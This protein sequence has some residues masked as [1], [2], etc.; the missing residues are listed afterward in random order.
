MSRASQTAFTM[1]R[2]LNVHL[3]RSEDLIEGHPANEVVSSIFQRLC[4]WST[5]T[6][7]YKLN[8]D[9]LYTG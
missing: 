9:L 4:D 5:D 3:E 2:H 7:M 8:Y 6:C 1:A